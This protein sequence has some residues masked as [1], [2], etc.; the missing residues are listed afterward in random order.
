MSHDHTFSFERPTDERE[1]LLAILRDCAGEVQE[2]T[3][4]SIDWETVI[5]VIEGICKVAGTAAALITLADKLI[6]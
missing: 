6:A 1:T 5:V 2:T 3:I 4:K